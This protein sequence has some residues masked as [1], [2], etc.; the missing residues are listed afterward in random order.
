MVFVVSWSMG[1]VVFWGSSGCQGLVVLSGGSVV[2]GVSLSLGFLAV[3]PL[4]GL[5]DCRHCWWMARVSAAAAGSGLCAAVAGLVA[6][7]VGS[8]SA[9]AAA[10]SA[11]GCGSF[12]LLVVAAAA[13]DSADAGSFELL[14]AAAAAACTDGGQAPAGRR[15]PRI[16]LN[17]IGDIV[18]SCHVMSFCLFLATLSLHCNFHPS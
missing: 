14:V 1:S 4:R 3:L 9:V 2:F 13:A 6:G 7:A 12:Q 18:A 17:L 11:T 16:S 10:E 15:R 5:V 8:A